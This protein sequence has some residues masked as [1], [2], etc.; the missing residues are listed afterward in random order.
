MKK[1]SPL[2]ALLAAAVVLLALNLVV[3]LS[4]PAA[5]ET[6]SIL[7]AAQ[8]QTGNVLRLEG[9]EFITTNQAGDTIH[10][11]RLGRFVNDGYE[12]VKSRTYYAGGSN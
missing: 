12:S 4:R 6:I 10:I 1:P 8:A 3:M 11:W 5:T 2:E 9:G 7:P